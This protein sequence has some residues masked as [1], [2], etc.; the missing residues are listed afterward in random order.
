MIKSSINKSKTKIEWLLF[1][2][3]K[4][5]LCIIIPVTLQKTIKKKSI[6]IWTST[7]VIKVIAWQ[8]LKSRLRISRD[9]LNR[10][11]KKTEVL[12][13]KYKKIGLCESN[14]ILKSKRS[15]QLI[16]EF[17]I[18]SNKI[19]WKR[20]RTRSW[21]LTFTYKI[22]IR[23]KKWLTILEYRSWTLSWCTLAPATHH[24][25]IISP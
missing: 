18:I 1:K 20:R 15:I 22:I 23:R 25:R 19:S 17:F 21:N 13:S 3:V 11:N 8:R 24:I 5:Q 2:V 16:L 6:I 10:K 14:Q 7:E 12:T 4:L 9:F